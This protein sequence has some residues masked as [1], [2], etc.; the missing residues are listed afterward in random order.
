MHFHAIVPGHSAALFIVCIYTCLYCNENDDFLSRA[1]TLLKPWQRHR[2]SMVEPG[3]W[4]VPNG[5]PNASNDRPS[6]GSIGAPGSRVS[7][8]FTPALLHRLMYAVLVGL[9]S[10]AGHIRA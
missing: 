2:R 7:H 6:V 10:V 5:L 9:A 1:V 4:L 3:H 8:R